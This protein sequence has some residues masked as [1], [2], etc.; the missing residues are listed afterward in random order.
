MTRSS[1]RLALPLLTL[2]LAPSAW[3]EPQVGVV[4]LQDSREAHGQRVGGEQRQ[5]LFMLPVYSSET[6]TTGPAGSTALQFLDDTRLQLGAQASVV[7]DEFAYDPRDRDGRLALTLGQGIFRYVSGDLP[8]QGISIRTPSASIAVR[9]TRMIIFVD[10]DDSTAA[11][12]LDG[13]ALFQGCDGSSYTVGGRQTARV[14]GDCS[15]SALSSGRGVPQDPAVDT[16][17]PALAGL[18]PEIDSPFGP[19]GRPDRIRQPGQ[20][21]TNGAG[22]GGGNGDGYACLLPDTRVLLAGGGTRPIAALAPGDRVLARDP[23]TGRL[24]PTRVTLVI[25]DHPREGHYLL[26]EGLAITNDHPVA[27][28]LG[29][30]VVWTPVEA[31]RVGDRIVSASGTVE[32]RQIAYRPGLV[33]TVYLETAA[34]SFVVGA[35]EETFVVN[36]RYGS[37]LPIGPLASIVDGKV[38]SAAAAGDAAP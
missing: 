19:Q 12:V 7:L 27:R 37:A 10:Q 14:L 30:G 21:P 33:E 24:V 8:K 28:V 6:V 32:V 36:G 2:A 20:G 16:E 15:D 1:L 29:D 31:L 23:A 17:A 38:A 9:G 25:T 4:A 3:A 26:N 13:L 5:L 18:Q 35:G 11:Y 34:G 22:K